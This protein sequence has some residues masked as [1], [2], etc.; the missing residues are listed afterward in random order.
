MIRP[1]VDAEYKAR[2]PIHH[3]ANARNLPLEI[4]A[5]IHDGHTGSV[6]VSHSLR[7]FNVIAAALDQ[8]QISE[9]LIETIVQTEDVPDNVPVVD[10]H[11][12]IEENYPRAIHLRRSAGPSRVTIFEGGHEGLATAACDW[13]ATHAKEK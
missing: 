13:L 2:S 5:G 7:A 11:S 6:E 4:S 12:S 3:L 9:D 8:P 1:E 10:A